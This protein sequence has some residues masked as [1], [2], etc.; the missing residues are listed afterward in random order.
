M[1]KSKGQLA[2]NLELLNYLHSLARGLRESKRDDLAEVV[3]V[4]TGHAAGLS[5][6]FLGES[7]IALVAI[8][9]QARQVLGAAEEEWLRQVLAQLDRALGE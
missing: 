2:S 8:E 4:A 9:A 5:T 6:E 3:E 7:R 1:A